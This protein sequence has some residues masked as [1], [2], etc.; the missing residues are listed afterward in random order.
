MARPA[1]TIAINLA[2]I[3]FSGAALSR[4]LLAVSAQ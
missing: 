1:I 3:W 4:D 2:H